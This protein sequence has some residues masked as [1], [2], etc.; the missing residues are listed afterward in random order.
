[1]L[2][3][4]FR[5]IILITV[6]VNSSNNSGIKLDSVFLAQKINFMVLSKVA[7]EAKLTAG[8]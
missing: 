2:L 6:S 1:M 8:T 7:K 4:S 3:F 5:S